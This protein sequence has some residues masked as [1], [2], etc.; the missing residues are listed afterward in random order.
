MTKA[1]KI[2]V[3]ER[4]YATIAAGDGDAAQ[5]GL[6]TRESIDRIAARAWRTQVGEVGRRRVDRIEVR[7]AEVIG[8]TIEAVGLPWDT[9]AER[10]QRAFDAATGPRDFAASVLSIEDEC[11]LTRADSA[12]KSARADAVEIVAQVDVHVVEMAEALARYH[13]AGSEGERRAAAEWVVERL[14][15]A[16]MPLLS[17]VMRSRCEWLVD[18]PNVANRGRR[19]TALALAMFGPSVFRD[20]RGRPCETRGAVF[21]AQDVTDKTVAALV[22]EIPDVGDSAWSYPAETSAA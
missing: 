16:S 11:T 5:R 8:A 18:S 21:S 22:D 9:F 19:A 2:G 7:T 13:A 4:W 15:S 10:V 20:D 17:A 14:A 3:L 6:V 1:D 12:A